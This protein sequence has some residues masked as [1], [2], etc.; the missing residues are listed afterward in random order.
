ME[1][2]QGQNQPQTPAA[3]P[4]PVVPAASIPAEPTK[5]KNGGKRPGA[6]R[7]KGSLKEENKMRLLM[8][9]MFVH[10]ID[11]RFEE[12]IAAKLDVALGHYYEHT[13][14]DGV[15]RIYKKAPN[16]IMLKWIGDQIMGRAPQK[17]TLDGEIETNPRGMTPE[18]EAALAAA[19]QYGIPKNRIAD[20][21]PAADSAPTDQG[22]G[23][24]ATDRA[25]K[26]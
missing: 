6:G 1:N 23:D 4:A 7:P 9:R 8:K 25:D 11:G 15:V 21:L 5:G 14:A 16:P 3:A 19:M 12:I 2:P 22:A 10:A 24:G 13:G 26:A 20:S 17:L 18:T